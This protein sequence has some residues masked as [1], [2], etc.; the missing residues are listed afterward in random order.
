MKMKVNASELRRLA[1]SFGKAGKTYERVSERLLKEY[2]VRVHGKAQ[3]LAPEF[4]RALR[5][6]ITLESYSDHVEIGVPINSEAGSYAEKIH[7][8]RGK[9]W[10]NLGERSVQKGATDKFI[11]RAYDDIK[12]RE[13]EMVDKI[14]EKTIKDIGI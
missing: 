2:G 8:E 4:S 5:D 12:R 10:H 11:F 9:T 14:I 1:R 13:K 3:A 7:D 6:S